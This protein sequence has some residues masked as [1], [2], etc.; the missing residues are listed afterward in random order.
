M[1]GWQYAF[2]LAWKY[3]DI[4]GGQINAEAHANQYT[5]SHIP[6]RTR[7]QRRVP[8]CVTLQT[9]NPKPPGLQRHQLSE[10]GRSGACAHRDHN[11]WVAREHMGTVDDINPALL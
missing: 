1:F 8:L 9:L 10:R 7:L 4:G 6:P 11:L 3:L 2:A 5:H